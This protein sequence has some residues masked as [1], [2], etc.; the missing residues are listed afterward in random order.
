MSKLEKIEEV[1]NELA[2]E[3][4]IKL[5]PNESRQM[6]AQKIAA[7]YSIDFLSWPKAVRAFFDQS[8]AM[9][10]H[11][12][13]VQDDTVTM[14]LRTEPMA[15][16]WLAWE[17]IVRADLWLERWR[18]EQLS[19]PNFEW[20]AFQLTN[21]GQPIKTLFERRFPDANSQ[22][23][24]G[25]GIGV[26]APDCHDPFSV[27]SSKGYSV[28]ENAYANNEIQS[29]VKTALASLSKFHQQIVRLHVG[30]PPASQYDPWS[31]SRI[32]GVFSMEKAEV[33]HQYEL[34]ISALAD[35]LGHEM[36]VL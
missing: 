24:S 22:L 16:F 15:T 14:I 10:R 23:A 6:R 27:C 31:L 5:F 20:I 29:I 28:E 33:A 8:R 34:A 2:R 3:A 35:R 11:R 13:E 9:Y 32:A 19:D 25:T 18:T 4:G 36:P 21:H 12:V 17:A 26:G 7:V 30:F 1:T